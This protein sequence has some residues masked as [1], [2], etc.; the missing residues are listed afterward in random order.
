MTSSQV[1]QSKQRDGAS[2]SIIPR[3]P[4]AWASLGLAAGL[5]AVVASSCCAIPLS[6]AALGASASVLG[7]LELVAA[8]RVPFLTLSTLAIIG[9]WVAW[10][11]TPSACASTAGCSS[12]SPSRATPIFLLAAS[13]ILIAAAS[14]GYIDPVLLKLV[15]G[16]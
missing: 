8:W 13:M 1:S 9:G 14:W 5:G 7:G 15:R 11:R 2:T 12:D 6:L 3:A 4:G 10:L 16:H